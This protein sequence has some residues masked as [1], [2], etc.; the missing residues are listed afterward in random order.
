MKMKYIITDFGVRNCDSLQTKEIQAVIDNAF[1]QGGGTVVV[2]KGVFLTAT[3]RLR[4]NIT[5]YLESGAVLKGSLN[6]DDYCEYLN[7]TLEPIDTSKYP[8]N[9]RSLNPTSRWHNS[10]I[11]AI[12][13]E[14]VSII[15]EPG[16]FIDGSNV[17][18]EVGEEH[19][20]G[21]HGIAMHNCKNLYFEG[22]TVLHSSNWAHN[23]Q[24]SENLHFK[25]VTVYAGHDGIDTFACDNV[26]IEDC[27]FRTGDDCIAGYDNKNV[28]V[29]NCLF[30]SS[31][32]AL[33]Y[34]GTDVLVENCRGIAPASYGFRG[35]LTDEEKAN[36][37]Q[38]T[39]HCRH[40]MHTAFQYYCDFRIEKL[41]NAPGNIVIRN[42]D[43]VN[44]NT[45][46]MHPF[47]GEH[48]WCANRPLDNITYENCKLL[49]LS[50]PA[51]LITVPEH[52]LTFKMK[53]VT[54]SSRE[55]GA[56]FPII[57]AKNCALVDLENVSLEG[58]KTPTIVTDNLDC[59]KV[60][61]GTKIKVIER[62]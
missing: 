27:E 34:G 1:L 35:Q 47:D 17:F 23:I 49:G 50:L 4:S 28:V 7:D 24:R 2:P 58:F 19:Y 32:S 26:L 6:P 61:G 57:E 62:K 11:K 5:L 45:I 44:P 59:V 10:L 38:S 18:D 40:T 21:P 15:G 8:E 22:Y 46:F 9:P 25:N 51:S 30:D 12:D 20:R 37:S 42:C 56:D 55:V 54:I 52:P 3:L 36:N 39:E 60:H 31:C 13:A 29:R 41:R 48:I 33:R 16:S 43:Y 14:N 53:N